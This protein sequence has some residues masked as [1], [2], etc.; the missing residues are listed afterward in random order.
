MDIKEFT[1]IIVNHDYCDYLRR[2]DNKVSYNSGLKKLRP[3]IGVLF[4]IDN[5]EYYAPLSSPKPKHMKLR[6]NMDLIKIK[7]G[8]LGVI[9][10]N[11][12]IPVTKNNYILFDMDK[13][14]KSLDEIKRIVLIR[15][16]LNWLNSKS[17][18]IMEK[19]FTLHFR[20]CENLLPSGIK[21]RCC[22]YPLLEEK[23]LEYNK[24]LKK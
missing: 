9:N 5:M 4:K 16:Q 21:D 6:N 8:L 15:K 3:F 24:E 14:N 12:M 13:R 7:N 2:F 20:Y 17:D 10:L 11:N 1:I 22:N 19:A 23:C 18:M